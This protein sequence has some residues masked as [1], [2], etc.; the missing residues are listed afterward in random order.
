MTSER[1]P[2]RW[3]PRDNWL[4]LVL[5]VALQVA[6]VITTNYALAVSG[7]L[8]ANP[9]MALYQAQLGSAWWLPKFVAVVWICIAA[10]LT[11]RRWPMIF[12][13]SYYVAVVAGNLAHL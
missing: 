10:S 7:N 3:V 4:M 5:F 8:E 2:R 12:A 1:E 11:R 6:D 9:I 13:V